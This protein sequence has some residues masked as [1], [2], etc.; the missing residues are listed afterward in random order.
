[1]PHAMHQQFTKIV[2]IKNHAN[3]LLTNAEMHVR[4]IGLNGS[5]SNN[6]LLVENR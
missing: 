5:K 2:A 4:R 3:S 6:V 1:M